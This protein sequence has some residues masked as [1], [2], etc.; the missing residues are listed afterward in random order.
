MLECGM[1]TD[2]VDLWDFYQAS[3]GRVAQRMIRRR[4]RSMWPDVSGLGVLG[5]G[6]ATP[7]L[8]PFRDEAARVVAVMPQAQGVIRWPFDEP[9]LVALADEEELPFPDL[10]IDRVLIVHGIETAEHLRPMMREV[11]RV[12]AGNGRLLVVAPNRQGMWARREGNPFGSG[13][14]Y[15]NTQLGRL[16]RDTMFT[17]LQSATA[18]YV[19]PTGWRVMLKAAEAWENIGSRWFPLFGGVVLVEATK[20]IYAAVPPRV[21]RRRR[22]LLPAPTAT[23]PVRRSRETTPPAAG[24]RGS[25]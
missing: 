23:A 17:P 2:V 25:R 10:S 14:P 20:Q 13:R 8:R 22:Q 7:F 16:M 6:Y 15:S 24:D 11:W 4:I 21:R 1:R 18:L 3:L 19:P 9:N 12:L 5:L